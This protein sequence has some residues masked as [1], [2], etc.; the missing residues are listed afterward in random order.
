MNLLDAISAAMTR[1]SWRGR[2]VY[3]RKDGSMMPMKISECA[4]PM[5]AE[6]RARA[7]NARAVALAVAGWIAEP[8]AE[9]VGAV[10]K[11]VALVDTNDFD[12]QELTTA[13]LTA[14]AA[15]VREMGE[16]G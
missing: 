6:Q 9:T 8:G 4:D 5:A 11:A 13:A 3:E 12:A 10:A 15:K 7:L 16:G 2:F 14:L 1:F